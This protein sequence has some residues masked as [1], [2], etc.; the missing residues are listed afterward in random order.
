MIATLPHDRFMSS[1][2]N[3]C[4]GFRGRCMASKSKG[5]VLNHGAGLPR[6]PTQWQ[7]PLFNFRP[8]SSSI[9]DLQSSVTMRSRWLNYL[10]DKPIPRVHMA[11]NSLGMN[12]STSDMPLFS[13]LG[14]GSGYNF[15]NCIS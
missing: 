10:V 12:A 6:I 1:H 15:G 11:R 7:V 2:L 14:L 13:C 5:V 4:N 3:Q 9:D 8:L